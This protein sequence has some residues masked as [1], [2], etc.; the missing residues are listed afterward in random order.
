[1][2]YQGKLIIIEKP[3]IKTKTASGLEL[4]ASDQAAFEAEQMKKWSKLK[5]HGIGEDVTKV[6]VGDEVL[7]TPKQLS[8]ADVFPMNDKLYYVVQESH[9][10][11]IH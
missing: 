8:Y 7:I 2:K 9:I 1:M 4:G 6:K 11:A 10:I 3:E 5:V